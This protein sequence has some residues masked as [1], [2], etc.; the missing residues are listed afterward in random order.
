MLFYFVGRQ[1][2][3]APIA[4]PT[5]NPPAPETTVQTV[6]SESAVGSLESGSVQQPPAQVVVPDAVQS[7]AVVVE[8]VDPTAA[9]AKGANTPVASTQWKC[10][11]CLASNSSDESKCV[12]C[13]LPRPGSV[14]ES[15]PAVDS[16]K[17]DF[18][19]F[20]GFGSTGPISFGSFSS[21]SAAGTATH[22]PF[23][24]FAASTT[25]TATHNPFTSFAASSSGFAAK[26][27][28]E[29]AK[30]Y[31]D[32]AAGADDD[33]APFE[34]APTLDAAAEN[35]QANAVLSDAVKDSKS[36]GSGEEN[37]VVK[38]KVRCKLFK[39]VK[40]EDGKFEPVDT[41]TGE[42]RV[43]SFVDNGAKFRVVMRQEKTS[44][45]LLNSLLHPQIKVSRDGNIVRFNT[46]GADLQV[47]S[48]MFR[49]CFFRS[50][51]SFSF[52]VFISIVEQVKEKSDA[53]TLLQQI[54]IGAGL[55]ASPSDD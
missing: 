51:Q 17:V 39:V 45:L 21:F 12:S 42:V 7:V 15:K 52:P 49:V 4:T 8:S 34:E 3:A 2:P 55:P 11:G 44:K 38:F 33:K 50:P 14:S 18:P 37:D 48:F 36:E 19:K 28:A 20:S 6:I 35:S 40:R 23:A 25:S 54:E 10:D 1:V 32:S 13:S 41:G 27:V 22:N 47:Q 29:A 26:P 24:S 16:A 5:V 31:A 9:A 43:S 30:E 46:I 53:K